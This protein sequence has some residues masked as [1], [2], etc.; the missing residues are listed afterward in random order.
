MQFSREY[1]CGRPEEVVTHEHSTGHIKSCATLGSN[2][3][4]KRPKT[5]HVS[6]LDARDRYEDLKS[7]SKVRQE[8]Y[9]TLNWLTELNDYETNCFRE[10]T[11]DTKIM[12]LSGC[13]SL[14]DFVKS[15]PFRKPCTSA[16]NV[17]METNTE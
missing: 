14:S 6:A 17:C 16:A 2:L 15:R 5:N 7:C 4:N 10:V 12:K 11:K 1:I 3:P 13:L 8:K 9:T